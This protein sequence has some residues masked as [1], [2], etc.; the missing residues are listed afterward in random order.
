MVLFFGFLCS[1]LAAVSSITGW[2]SFWQHCLLCVFLWM[3]VPIDF[4]GYFSWTGNGQEW[5]WY[6]S[7]MDIRVCVC[8]V[9]ACSSSWFVL[10]LFVWFSFGLLSTCVTTGWIFDISLCVNSINHQSI[11]PY[12]ST[13]VGALCNLA[14]CIGAVLVCKWFYFPMLVHSNIHPWEVP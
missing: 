6:C 3:D 12:D 9:S 10:C 11:L 1:L 4:S 14:V 8:L 13:G 7:R 5:T 2:S